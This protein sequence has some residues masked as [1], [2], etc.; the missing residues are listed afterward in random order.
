MLGSNDF[1]N[2]QT[3]SSEHNERIMSSKFHHH[4]HYQYNQCEN[5]AMPDLVSVK[6]RNGR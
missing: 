4:H 5:N 6:I 1:A 3:L 2:T